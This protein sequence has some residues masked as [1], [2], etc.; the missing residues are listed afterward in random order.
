MTEANEG[1]WPMTSSSV[2]TAVHDY[3]KYAFQDTLICRAYR[4]GVAGVLQGILV[5]FGLAG[6]LLTMKILWRYR[7]KTATYLCLFWLALADLLVVGQLGFL[8][9]PSAFAKETGSVMFSNDLLVYNSVY[10]A[11]GISFSLLVSTWLTVVVTWFRYVS[12]CLPYKVKEYCN[13]RVAKIQVFIIILTSVCF[14]FPRI[15]ESKIVPHHPGATMIKPKFTPFAK[16]W[17]Y[18]VV[19][20]MIINYTVSFGLPIILLT[21]MTVRLMLTLK[22]T[23]TRRDG[24]LANNDGSVHDELHK[25]LIVVIVI[26]I[27][28]RIFE[29]IRIILTFVYPG[30]KHCGQILFYYEM[31]AQIMSV[32][33]SA[34]NVIVYILFTPRFKKKQLVINISVEASSIFLGEINKTLCDMNSYVVTEVQLRLSGCKIVF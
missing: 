11:F 6:N 32:T 10:V 18:S 22:A 33:N 2:D 28:T 4:F 5:L 16:T 27:I 25:S 30:Q 26:F 21:V 7:N 34:V 19:Y 9:I 8:S 12:V 3:S 13:L 17:S 1:S 24:M 23:R 29:P 15:F 31:W 14:S 20:S